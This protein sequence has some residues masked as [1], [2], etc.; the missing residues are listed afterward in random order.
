MGR[1]SATRQEGRHEAA[2]LHGES[3]SPL[4]L[5]HS[6]RSISAYSLWHEN[7]ALLRGEEGRRLEAASP[8]CLLSSPVAGGGEEEACLL[9]LCSA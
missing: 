1:S 6:V 2:S 8:A 3:L 5:L 9:L 7:S 4:C